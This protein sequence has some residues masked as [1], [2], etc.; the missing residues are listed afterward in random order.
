MFSGRSVLGP[1]YILSFFLSFSAAFRSRVLAQANSVARIARP[2]GMRISAGPGSRIIAIPTSKT[3]APITAMTSFRT[4][5]KLES[6]LLTP[7]Y[8]AM[9]PCFQKHS[10][11]E[12]PASR[13]APSSSKMEKYLSSSAHSAKCRWTSPCVIP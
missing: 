11:L 12:N 4:R 1:T 5:F 10:G 2:A 3:V 8:T 9:G 6:Q 7:P 13:S